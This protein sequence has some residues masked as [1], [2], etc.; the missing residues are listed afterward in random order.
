MTKSKAWQRCR[1]ILYREL[2]HQLI[3]EDSSI[4]DLCGQR[5]YIALTYQEPSSHSFTS[6][7]TPKQA[8]VADGRT[9][10]KRNATSQ[11]LLSVCNPSQLVCISHF[12]GS[13]GGLQPL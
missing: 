3:I 12:L 5:A 4:P 9:R 8:N 10:Q 13:K 2:L 6:S 7:R 11:N 1:R